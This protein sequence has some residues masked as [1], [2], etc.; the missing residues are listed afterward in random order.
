MV[1]VLVNVRSGSDNDVAVC[2]A[3]VRSNF[4]ALGD[5][6]H[7]NTLISWSPTNPSERP[8]LL[9]QP[10]IQ[11]HYPLIDLTIIVKLSLACRNLSLIIT[12]KAKSFIEHSQCPTS[13]FLFGLSN[14]TLV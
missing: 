2:T 8:T 4:E 12:A 5:S 10:T 3:L 9:R 13:I 7:V 6:T 1:R 11:S 14:F